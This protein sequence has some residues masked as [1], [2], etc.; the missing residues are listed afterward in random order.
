MIAPEQVTDDNLPEFAAEQFER[1][2]EFWVNEHRKTYKSEPDAG[3]LKGFRRLCARIV[4]A[5]VQ[6]HTRRLM[7]SGSTSRFR[8]LE[9]VERVILDTPRSAPLDAHKLVEAVREGLI[10]YSFTRPV[11]ETTPEEDD[12]A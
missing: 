12:G 10:D 6:E 5:Q 8:A 9:N 2:Y 11:T 7:L 4:A 1:N 3:L